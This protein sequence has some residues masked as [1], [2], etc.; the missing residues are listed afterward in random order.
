SKRLPGKNI[1]KFCGKPLIARTIAIARK[2]SY[3]DKIVVST[4][5]EKI[6]KIARQ[7]RADVPFIRPQKLARVRSKTMDVILHAM[8]FFE[9]NSCVFD[10]IILLQ[11]TSPLRSKVDIERA[12]KM[13]VEKKAK[14]VVSVHPASVGDSL[15]NTLPRDLNMHRFLEKSITNKKVYKI[16]GAIYISDWNFIKKNKGWY[17]KK[18]FAFIMNKRNSIDIDEKEDFLAAEG[19]A[20]NRS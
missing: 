11:P 9:K 3:I 15:A 18:T 20:R 13:F 12:F 1:K 2:V 7:H 17:S 19:L 8:N 14:A 16:N 4:D 5:S 6:A 10:V